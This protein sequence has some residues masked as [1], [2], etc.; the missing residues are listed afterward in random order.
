MSTYDFLL[1]DGHFARPVEPDLVI[2][3]GDMPTSKPL[4]TWLAE[5]GADQI[6]VDPSGGWER[7]DEAGRGVGARRPG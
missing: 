3:F 6:V 1:R 2:R 7:A 4:R 5:I